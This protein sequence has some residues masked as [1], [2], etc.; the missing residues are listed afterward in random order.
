M[1]E[2]EYL[3]EHRP[4]LWLLGLQIC[5]V[6]YKVTMAKVFATLDTRKLICA[7]CGAN[8]SIFINIELINVLINH[9]R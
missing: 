4:E 7:N 9:S 2:V 8:Q 1:G 3:D 6:C 5:P